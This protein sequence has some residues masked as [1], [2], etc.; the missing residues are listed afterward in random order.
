[1]A[2][3]KSRSGGPSTGHR[4]TNSGDR[5]SSRCPSSARNTTSSGC[6]PA[7]PPLART[8]NPTFS[9]AQWNAPKRGKPMTPK[10]TVLLVAYVNACCPQQAMD[11]YTP[12]AWHDLLGDLDLAGCRQAVVTVAKRQPFV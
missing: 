12:D 11:E 6:K 1:M 10:E 5:T 9:G 4:T 8:A 2:A 3:P 7:A